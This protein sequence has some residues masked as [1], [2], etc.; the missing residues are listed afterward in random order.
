MW[1]EAQMSVIEQLTPIIP[2]IFNFLADYPAF[3]MLSASE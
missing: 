1:S 3:W 2:I